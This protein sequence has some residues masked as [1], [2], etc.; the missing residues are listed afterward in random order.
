MK[1]ILIT[2][3]NGLLGQS[4]RLLLSKQ[5]EI[6]ATGLN[7]D[8]LKNHNHAYTSLD[9]SNE[10]DCEKILIEFLPDV[11]INTAAITD[12]DYCELNTKK[13][14][15]I[16]THSIN[17]FLSYCKKH[18]KKFIHLSTDFL[19]DG[20][21]GPYCENSECNPI[22]Y[23]GFS[24]MKA[25]N[26]IINSKLKNFSIIRTCLVYGEKF[27]SN[28]I[29][30]WVKKKLE[31]GEVLNIVD[32]QYR[33]PTLFYDLSQAIF[34]IIKLDLKGIYNISGG[35]YLS[36][37]DFVCKIVSIF[38][39]DK[40][41]VKRCKSN[42]INQKAQRPKKSGLLIDKATKDFNFLPTKME[43]YLKSIK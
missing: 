42:K 18:N 5:Y 10:K 24:K 30:M 11:V 20:K 41:L 34:E 2:G 4:L 23:Y 38:G 8:R 28:N 33:T 1:K 21:S 32:D 37:F 39:Y 12:V 35:E 27:D 3:G 22:N 15:D 14:L 43:V 26:L 36:I 19:F 25:E 9:V 6:I 7:S 16:N 13:C 17:N 40:S 31:K 29:F